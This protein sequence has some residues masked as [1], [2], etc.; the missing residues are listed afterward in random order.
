MISTFVYGESLHSSLAEM[1]L[2]VKD[3]YSMFHPTERKGK[4]FDLGSGLGKPCV[5]AALTL[6]EFLS[7]CTG[8]E[9]LDC[10][11]HKSQ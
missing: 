2:Y 11:F 6:P 3:R 5:T 10:L 9:L 7:E 4:F 1:I 8:F